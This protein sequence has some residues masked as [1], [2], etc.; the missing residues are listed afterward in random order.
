MKNYIASHNTKLSQLG[1]VEE[2]EPG[3]NCQ[4]GRDSCPLQGN[5]LVPGLIY[6][7]EL[8]N[9]S[10]KE[11]YFGQTAITF[12]KRWSNHKSDCKIPIKRNSSTFSTYMWSLKD[13]GEEGKVK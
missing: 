1:A 13:R 4:K 6:K 7:A 3:Y 2:Q 12:K 10:T 8:E 5:C 9:N 11:H